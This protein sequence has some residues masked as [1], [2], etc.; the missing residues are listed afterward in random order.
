MKILSRQEVVD[1]LVNDEIDTIK[2]M[3]LED[4]Y[5]YLDSIVRDGGIAG[6][7]NLCNE[8][9]LEEYYIKFDEYIDIK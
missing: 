8:D 6:F 3:I 1:Q 2:Q 4:D 9:L 7:S 5:S